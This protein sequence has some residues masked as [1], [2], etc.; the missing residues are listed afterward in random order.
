MKLLFL[1]TI[2][3][4]GCSPRHIIFM[5]PNGYQVNECRPTSYEVKHHIKDHCILA[6]EKA[7]WRELAE[8]KWTGGYG[9]RTSK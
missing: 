1:L 8:A 6:Y 9:P 2:L 4:A 5:S 3:L 7:G